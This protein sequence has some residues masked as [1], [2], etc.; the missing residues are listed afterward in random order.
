MRRFGTRIH[1]GFVAISAGSL[2]IL[3]ATVWAQP[4]TPTIVP[5]THQEA[6]TPAVAP[7]Q[8]FRELQSFP[9]ETVQAIYALRAGADWLTRMNQS[10]G[11][12]FPGI[13]PATQVIAPDTNP[14]PQLQATLALAHAAT[15]TGDETYAVRAT[16]AVLV[17]RSQTTVPTDTPTLRV[18]QVAASECNPVLYAALLAQ[19]I[20]ALPGS[21][22]GLHQEA[23]Q[24][25]AFV[26]QQQQADGSFVQANAYGPALLTLALQ[27]RMQPESSPSDA[28]IRGMVA[29][30]K[31]FQAAPSAD[32]A[33]AILPA[34]CECA[35]QTRKPELTTAALQ[36]GDWLCSCQYTR[37][38]APQ[39]GWAGSFRPQPGAT[40]A[41][42]EPSADAASI[43]IGLAAVTRLTRHVP[44]LTRHA[45]FRTATV[46]A[47]EFCRRLQYTP[48]STRGFESAFAQRFLVGGMCR[49]P[50]DPTAAPVATAQLVEA[51]RAYLTSGAENGGP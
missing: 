25:C 47:L 3:S 6:A 24:L 33:A 45:R 30:M 26:R 46:D 37:T 41:G 5:A 20:W 44:D 23:Q 17:L 43:A 16:Q 48:E 51:H 7:I 49:V 40:P 11:R 14:L 38:D 31:Q 29:A 35:L 34:L 36:L 8:R 28:L 42:F 15:F 50:S 9:R 19:A 21:D 13:N 18:P 1:N 22:A 27:T 2:F 32:F 12:F 4:A 10:N 39:V